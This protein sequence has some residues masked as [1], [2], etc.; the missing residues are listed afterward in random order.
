MTRW[1]IGL[2]LAT[3]G[4]DSSGEGEDMD[5][6]TSQDTRSGGE[7]TGGGD[8]TENDDT[9][10]DDP[11]EGAFPIWFSGFENGFPG[12]WFDYAPPADE[13][14][15]GWDIVEAEDGVVPLEGTHMYK[16]KTGLKLK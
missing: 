16:G 6:G 12:E 3:A 8:G 1:L 10:E 7:S 13:G 9:S 14:S 5:G 15:A 4:C 11:P 2:L